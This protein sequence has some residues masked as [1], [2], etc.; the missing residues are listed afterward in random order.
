[1]ENNQ[2]LRCGKRSTIRGLCRA[3]YAQ[4]NKAKKV[5]IE[6]GF[7]VDLFDAELVQR[8]LILPDQKKQT[9]AF[10]DVLAEMLARQKSN[11]TLD[12]KASVSPMDIIST[13]ADIE[14]AKIKSKLDVNKSKKPAHKRKA[15]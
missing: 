13:Q 14:A 1:M 4:F 2:C 15:E 10:E 7:P 11:K 3:H 5:A 9:D 8:G 12:Q 6:L